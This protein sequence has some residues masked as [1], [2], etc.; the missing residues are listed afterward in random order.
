MH[1]VVA[2]VSYGMIPAA[3]D[4]HW[5]VEKHEISKPLCPAFHRLDKKA[6][7]AYLLI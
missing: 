3:A 7:C 4:L 5:S 6:L 1:N 2:D